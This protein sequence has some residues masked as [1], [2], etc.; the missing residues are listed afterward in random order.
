MLPIRF[1]TPPLDPE[2][3]KMIRKIS[4][5]TIKN[6][7]SDTMRTAYNKI[8]QDLEPEDSFGMA[9]IEV[10]EPKKSFFIPYLYH[11]DKLPEDIQD[12]LWGCFWG[13]Y[14]YY[15]KENGLLNDK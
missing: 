2:H 6:S 1:N 13:S 7:M 4:G 10:G 11:S 5:Q 12:F 8:I 15:C 14:E 3:W 9:G